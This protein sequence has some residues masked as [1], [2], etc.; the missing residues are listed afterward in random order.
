MH[1]LLGW[2]AVSAEA[3]ALAFGHVSTGLH[4][5]QAGQ[6][7]Q[8]VREFAIVTERYSDTHAAPEALYWSAKALEASGQPEPATAQ[9]AE[10]A[11]RFPR[12][13]Y[14]TT[15]IVLAAAAQPAVPALPPPPPRPVA[16][17]PVVVVKK[18]GNQTV[19]A[20]DDKTFATL[21]AFEAGLAEF[22]Q[23]QPADVVVFRREDDVDLQMV[24]DAINALEKAG[25]TYRL[26]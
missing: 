26:P 13:E 3:L 22:K 25:I 24:V 11:R 20:L 10:L 12:S 4:Y 6:H 5:L 7:D 17:V 2:L 15:N 23:R 19:V 21:A 18:V 14:V 16:K 8:A 9:L 1:L